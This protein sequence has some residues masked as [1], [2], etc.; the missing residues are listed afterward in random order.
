M[1]FVVDKGGL[2]P[3]LI[4]IRRTDAQRRNGSLDEASEALNGEPLNISAAYDKAHVFAR[5]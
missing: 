5:G 4:I 2:K 1:S 3:G